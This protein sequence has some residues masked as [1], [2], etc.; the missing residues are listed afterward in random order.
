MRVRASPPKTHKHHH[1]MS[2]PNSNST[3][4]A[5]SDVFVPLVEAI[6]EGNA[7]AVYADWVSA[8]DDA[9]SV[10]SRGRSDESYPSED[11]N[12]FIETMQKAVDE[13]RNLHKA[14]CYKKHLHYMFEDYPSLSFVIDSIYIV[15]SVCLDDNL[16]TSRHTVEGRSGNGSTLWRLYIHE[17]RDDM[18]ALDLTGKEDL[19]SKRYLA[20]SYCKALD[21]ED[22]EVSEEVARKFIFCLYMLVGGVYHRRLTFS[23]TLKADEISIPE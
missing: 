16:N 8:L 12:V 19:V 21:V 11:R 20:F 4:T 14:K 9:A 13:A 18:L 23:P 6:G 22:T 2:K 5:L 15:S 10:A 3:R 7:D 1:I 17:D